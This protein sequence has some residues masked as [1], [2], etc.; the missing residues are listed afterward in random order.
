[1]N[2]VVLLTV[3]SD[4]SEVHQVWSLTCHIHLPSLPGAKRIT[5]ILME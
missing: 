5:L 3:A 4:S 2:P 1:V